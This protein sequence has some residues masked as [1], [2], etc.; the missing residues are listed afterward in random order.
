MDF[1]IH[2]VPADVAPYFGDTSPKLT[3]K[4]EALTRYVLVI[5][6]TNDMLVRV[7]V[8]FFSY[9][10]YFWLLTSPIVPLLGRSISA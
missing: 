1:C 3:F 6:D 2:S 4:R 8:F 5:E 7:S 10:N 9:I